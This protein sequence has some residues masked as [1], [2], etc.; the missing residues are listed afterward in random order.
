MQEEQ[1]N[2]HVSPPAKILLLAFGW[3]CVGLGAL[4]AFMPVLPTTPFLLLALW[5]FS[6]S[7]KRFHDWLYT[8]PKF[9][10][11][12]RAWRDHK[13]VPLRA[14]ILAVTTM[15]VSFIYVTFFYAETMVLPVIMATIMVPTALW[16][17]SRDSQIPE[18][19]AVVVGESSTEG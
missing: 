12:L 19:R 11:S 13:V 6:R 10:P 17:I 15:M 14:K 3:L 5:A 8:H 18:G 9:G 7:S 2:N 16:L 1:V 4:G